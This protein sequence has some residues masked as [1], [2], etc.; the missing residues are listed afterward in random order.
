MTKTSGNRA[1]YVLGVLCLVAVVNYVD[2]QILSIL[3]EPVKL[4]LHA[5]D[6]AMGLLTGTAFAFCYV[7]SS[8]PIAHWADRGGRRS[9]LAGCVAIWSLMTGLCGLTQNFLQLA[10]AR[11]AMA[12][13]E[14]GAVPISQALVS[15]IYSPSR[16]GTVFG[17]LTAAGTVGGAFGLFFGGWIS[18]HFDWRTAFLVVAFPGLLIAAL[19]RFTIKEPPRQA[20]AGEPR[21]PDVST[22]STLR[23]LLRNP[24]FRWLLITTAPAGFT[25]Y[26]MISWAP[27]FMIREHAMAASAVGLGMGVATLVGQAGGHMMAGAIADRLARKDVRWY[28]WFAA[29]GSLCAIPFGFAFLFVRDENIALI[30]YALMQLFKS[31]WLAP[32]YALVFHLTPINL[33]ARTSSILTC[34]LILFGLGLGPIFVGSVNDLLRPIFGASSIRYSLSAVVALLLPISLLFFFISGRV[35]RGAPSTTLAHA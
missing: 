26:A 11:S 15:D 29:I 33:R 1:H 9:V 17:I 3:L 20:S 8:Y 19:V 32:T 22:L 12:F 31:A 2:R 6:T 23:V 4:D 16:R 30:L 14:S 27:T 10:L 35:G 24:G 34:C 13:A 18:D 28:A 21:Q 7:A 5:S 25:T